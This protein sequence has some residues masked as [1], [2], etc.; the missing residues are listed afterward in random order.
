MFGAEQSPR[1][2]VRRCVGLSSAVTVY[3]HTRLAT[4]CPAAAYTRAKFAAAKN[5]PARAAAVWTGGTVAAAAR[6]ATPVSTRLQAGGCKN[7]RMFSV[8]PA[9]KEGTAAREVHGEDKPQYGGDLH[10]RSQ[11]V[12][13]EGAAA[14]VGHGERQPVVAQRGDRPQEQQQ[15]RA[16][17]LGEPEQR[18]ELQSGVRSEGG[19]SGGSGVRGGG[20]GGRGGGG[21]VKQAARHRSVVLPGGLQ[22]QFSGVL[23][24]LQVQLNRVGQTNT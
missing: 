24:R 19:V 8:L 14:E 15:Q 2:E 13:E 16:A 9:G 12:A 6:Q 17:Q 18:A 3:L 20:S 21:C 23:L 4:A 7:N 11:G 22:Q 10:Q 1:A 5:L